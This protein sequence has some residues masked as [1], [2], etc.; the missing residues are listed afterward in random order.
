MSRCYRY[1]PR[2]ECVGMRM[3][4]L[5]RLTLARPRLRCRGVHRSDSKKYR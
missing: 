3:V 1:V 5:L 4:L 2:S